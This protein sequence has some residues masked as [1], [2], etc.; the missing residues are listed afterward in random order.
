MFIGTNDCKNRNWNID[1]FKR[2]YVELCKSFKNMPSKP[3]VFVVVPPPVYK[4][5]FGAVNISI[6]NTILPQ[7][8][9]PLAKECGLGDDQVINLFEAMGGASLSR[10]DFYCSGQHCDGYHPIDAGQN[11]MAA[12]ILPKVISYYMKNPKGAR[13]QSQAPAATPA[14]ADKSSSKTAAPAANKPTS[15]KA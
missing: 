15:T 13:A 11:Q 2:D 4:D 12:T 7:L 3:D 1:H 14:A 8:I 5:G 6:T 9:E 10:P